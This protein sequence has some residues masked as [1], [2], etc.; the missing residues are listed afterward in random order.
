MLTKYYTVLMGIILSLTLL[1]SSCAAAPK[2]PAEY[3]QA[4]ESY[5]AA[6][7]VAEF[8]GEAIEESSKIDSAVPQAD[9]ERIV[10]KN[11]NLSIVV[12]DPSLTLDEITRMT[13]V[14]G[15]YVVA[16]NLYQQELGDGTTVTQGSMT[17][18]VPAE[19]LNDALSQ[20]KSHSDRDPLQE[21]INSQDV[22]SEYTD[23]QSRLRNL[24]SAET[25]L[26]K[27]MEDANKTEDVLAV[28]NELVRVQEQIEVIKGQIKY[29]DQSAAM[30]AINVELL[31]NEAVQPLTIGG[32][33]P[34]GVAKNALQAL[35]N[36]IKFLINSVIWIVILLFPVVLIIGLVFIL[37]IYLILRALRRR[38][39]RRALAEK[40]DTSSS[41]ENQ[42]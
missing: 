6:P 9:I 10:I 13:E 15:G 14:M 21:S 36:T 40:S 5:A 26:Q 18:R 39:N 38:R 7:P 25:Q 28:Y 3:E 8:A 1:F 37:P 27:I 2:S 33:Q 4:V 30:S 23:L 16:A 42:T 35:I 20:I 17:I 41:N 31:A 12:N 19:K 34:G 32:W 11:A 22:T 24:Q 29:Y